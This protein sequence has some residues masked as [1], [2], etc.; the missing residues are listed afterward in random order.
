M[1]RHIFLDKTATLI[2]GSISNTGLNPVAELNYGDAVTRIILHFDDS[3]L[4]QMRDDK[5]L[6]VNNV[7][8]HLK[9]TNCT[10]IN[11]IPYEKPLHYGNTC[12][13]KE[14]ASSFFVLAMKLPQPFDEGRG[15][16]FV[17]DGWVKNRRAF[18]QYGCNWYQSYNGKAWPEEGVYSLDTIADE[19]KKFSSG[20]TSNI[21]DRQHFDFGDEQLDIDITKYVLDVLDGEE[22]NGIMLCFTPRLER[23]FE[24]VKI[25]EPDKVFGIAPS[26]CDEDGT[27]ALEIDDTLP[28]TVIEVDSLPEYPEKN[29]PAYIA[30]REDSGDTVTFYKKSEIKIKQQYVG[31]F[32]NH[33]NTFFHPYVEVNL[34]NTI[35]DDRECFFIGKK[36]RLYLY[37]NIGGSPENLDEMPVCTISNGETPEVKQASKGVYYVEFTLTDVEPD[38]IMYDTW[39][40][41]IYDGQDQGEVELEFV[42]LAQNRYFNIGGG[43]VKHEHLVP[44]LY[45]INDDEKVKQGDVREVVV[46]F[47][48]KYTTDK[49]ETVADAWY[50]LY[51]KDGNRQIDIFGGYRPVERTF[52]HNYFLIHTADLIP[53]NRYYVDIKIKEGNE[54][55]YYEDRLHFSV[56]DDVTVRYS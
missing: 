47:R 21:I 56:A 54:T 28:P 23:Q 20:G 30:V 5:T 50:R 1:I 41:L 26:M 37:A 34:K 39:S 31:F 16:E 6:D 29:S 12:G 40:N 24:Y 44:N 8:F 51:T 42:A 43:M 22:N 46:D 3:E 19:Y 35:Q 11:G 2:K 13:E 15:Y 10:A 33:T 36:N 48:K 53:N 52:L 38:T 49:R 32:T 9:M 14:R 27:V 4:K 55:R 7:E 45:G 18:S 17:D 25:G